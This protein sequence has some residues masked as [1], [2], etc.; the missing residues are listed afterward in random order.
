MFLTLA[1]ALALAQRCAPDVAPE[2]LLSVAHAE[3]GF[4]PLSIGV[5]GPRPQALHPGTAAAAAALARQL[6]SQGRN[7]DVGIGQINV[8]TLRR[9]NLSLADAFDPCLNLAAAARVLKDNYRGATIRAPSAQAALR[10]AFSLYNTGDA[11]RGFRNGYVGR[12]EASAARI[13][14]ALQTVTPVAVAT[15]EP[16]RLQ[17]VGRAPTSKP[18]LDVFAAPSR[19]LV[20][21]GQPPSPEPP[22]P[23]PSG[24]PS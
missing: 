22:L 13:V 20:W 3:S 15:S 1:A 5:N 9:L 10:V 21:G 7:I 17:P 2:T 6:V 19:A 8:R 4:D 14:P 24:D 18:S 11:S 16:V 23:P 12:V